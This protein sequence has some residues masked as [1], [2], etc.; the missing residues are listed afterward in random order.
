[1]NM[2]NRTRLDSIDYDRRQRVFPY[3]MEDPRDE[4]E[5]NQLVQGIVREWK[6]LAIVFAIGSICSILIALYLP[7]VYLVEA[8]LRAPSLHELGDIRDQ[9]LLE[10]SPQ[11]SITRVIDLILSPE[12]QQSAFEKSE[13]GK[14]RLSQSSVPTNVQVAEQINSNL[15]LNVIKHEYYGLVKGEKVPLKA[16]S[17]TFKSKEPELAAEF[18][19]LLVEQAQIDAMASFENDV[20][21]AKNTKIGNIQRKLDALSLAAK[22]N[23]EAEI[24]RLQEANRESI[25]KQQQLIELK[26]WNAN[27]ERKNRIIHLTEALATAESLGIKEPITWDD[28]RPKRDSTQI[29]NDINGGDKAEPL[30]FLGT[31]LLQAELS[32]LKNRPDDRPYVAGLTE[33]EAR[34]AELQ[35]DSR[36]ATLILRSDDQIHIENYDDLQRQLKDLLSQSDQFENAQLAVVNQAATVPSTPMRNPL[37]IIAIG[38]FLSVFLAFLVVFI[39]L[40]LNKSEPHQYRLSAVD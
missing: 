4:V 22:Q 3:Y 8:I 5:L 18:V 1:M 17:V 29:I 39:R 23:R 34:L 25:L 2:G 19:Q 30:Y 32:M 20:R 14:K 37:V 31:R 27:Q 13:L 24:A 16:I 21:A 40:S 9:E 38:L 11:L 33:L 28:L 7:R 12:V 26:V 35:N 15:S 36:I 10:V 6:A